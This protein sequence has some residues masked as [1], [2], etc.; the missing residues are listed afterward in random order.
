MRFNQ[1]FLISELTLLTTVRIQEKKNPQG[2]PLQ[3]VDYSE[4][5]AT[6]T[7]YVQEKVLPLS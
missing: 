5:K 2:V 3:H 6:E 1:R 7:P 4:L